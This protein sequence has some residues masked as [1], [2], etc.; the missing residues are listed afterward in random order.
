MHCAAT[1][2][3]VLGVSRFALMPGREN[4][5]DVLGRAA[6]RKAGLERGMPTRSG[7]CILLV[8]LRAIVQ[9]SPVVFHESCQVG[10]V[11]DIPCATNAGM[12]AATDFSACSSWVGRA[13]L[14]S[15]GE[16]AC[17]QAAV[18]RGVSL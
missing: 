12:I 15:R 13:I 6:A 1:P 3:L 10:P 11:L 4:Q 17:L 8:A 2:L 9:A 14:T 16:T 7:R 18:R 5:H